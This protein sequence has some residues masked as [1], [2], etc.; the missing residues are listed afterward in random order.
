M[1]NATGAHLSR[2][3]LHTR[4]RLHKAFDTMHWLLWMLAD[5]DQG[6]TRLDA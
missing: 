6:G 4:S 3:M 1:T 2:L 5:L